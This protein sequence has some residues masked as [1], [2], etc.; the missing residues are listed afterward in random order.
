MNFSSFSSP[1]Q[2][3]P[4]G[5]TIRRLARLAALGAA[6]AAWTPGDAAAEGIGAAVGPYVSFVLGEKLGIGYGVETVVLIAPD[7]PSCRPGLGRGWGIGPALQLGGINAS[8][9]QLVAALAAGGVLPEDGRPNYDGLG[10]IGEA[11]VALHVSKGGARA[12]VHTGVSF[13][14]PYF[15]YG[16]ARAEWLLDSYSLGG[17]ARF[18]HIFNKP[19]TCTDG[20]PLRGED[21]GL[22][23]SATASIGGALE[24]GGTLAAGAADREA[25]AAAWSRDA[26]AEA[27]SVPAFLQLAGDL[28]ALG[29]PDALVDEAI[30]AAEDE[31]RH[32]RACAVI[33]SRLA[34]RRITP[35]LPASPLRPS[36][37]GP[38]GMRRVA[39]ESWLDGCLG[40]GA[41]AARAGL[42]AHRASEPFVAGVRRGIAREE[43]RHA[44]LAWKVLA[45]AASRGGDE[46]LDAVH[47]VRD[48]EIA[49]ADEGLAERDARAFGRV[50]RADAEALH[51]RHA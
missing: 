39:V 32:A 42:A 46:I 17:G 30:A 40:E 10:I 51:A 7:A 18:P 34:G 20:R 14:S 23:A 35:A 41:A 11:G 16:F 9:F 22:I 48:A 8:T 36:L 50:G 38:D 26:L 31:V 47:A 44:E 24:G 43:H 28:L 45:W 3:P 29:A 49:P 25:V 33:A 4:R 6:C 19:T 37:P 12:G 15:A 21:G 13:Q 2:F 1:L 27:A 5:R